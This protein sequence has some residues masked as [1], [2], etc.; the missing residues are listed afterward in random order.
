MSILLAF[1][2]IQQVTT[3]DTLQSPTD[4]PLLISDCSFSFWGRWL[5]VTHGCL[6]STVIYTRTVTLP[7]SPSQAKQLL[8]AQSP[9]LLPGH[10]HNRGLQVGTA[11]GPPRD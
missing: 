1:E 4:N 5:P 8:Q 11:Q 7:S 9:S 2:P 6:G 10:P 3:V